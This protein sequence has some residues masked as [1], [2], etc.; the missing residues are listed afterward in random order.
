MKLI[1]LEEQL[2]RMRNQNCD[3]NTM[4]RVVA[5]GVCRELEQVSEDMTGGNLG[6]R[7]VELIG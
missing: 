6:C 7:V 4:V 5:N 1:E 2:R 3:D